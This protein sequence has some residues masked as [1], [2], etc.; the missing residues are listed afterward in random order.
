MHTLTEYNPIDLEVTPMGALL[1]VYVCQTC[2]CECHRAAMPINPSRSIWFGD[3]F[4]GAV[5]GLCD[6]CQ[7]GGANG[8]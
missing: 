2:G 7:N 4:S 5:A 6:T 8:S 1:T 3:D